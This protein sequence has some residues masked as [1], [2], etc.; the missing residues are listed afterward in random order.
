MTYTHTLHI[1]TAMQNER[2]VIFSTHD[3]KYSVEL[4]TYDILIPQGESG[5]RAQTKIN[6]DT[7]GLNIACVHN[8]KKRFNNYT[9]F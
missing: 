7:L 4:L 3:T 8:E 9:V 6:I 1:H 5:L 2:T